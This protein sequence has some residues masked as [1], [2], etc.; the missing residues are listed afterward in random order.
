[1]GLLGDPCQHSQL[2]VP[3]SGH[4]SAELQLRAGALRVPKA[5]GASSRAWRGWEQ[6]GLTAWCPRVHRVGVSLQAEHVLEGRGGAGPAVGVPHGQGDGA[7]P[8]LC[9]AP[10]AGQEFAHGS[11]E[12]PHEEWV[13]DGVH[14]AVAV[15]QPGE[16]IEESSWDTATNCLGG[17]GRD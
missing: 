6:P 1:M 2:C 9:G 15:A 7:G 8:G 12:V 10:A 14:G 4:G 17:H 13:D 11:L 5:D 3:R 16:H